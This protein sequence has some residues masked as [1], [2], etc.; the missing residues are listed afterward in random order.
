MI[1]RRGC[2]EI[3]RISGIIHCDFWSVIKI[4]TIWHPSYFFP[5]IFSDNNSIQRSYERVFSKVENV[6]KPLRLLIRPSANKTRAYVLIV[7]SAGRWKVKENGQIPPPIS[8]FQPFVSRFRSFPTFSNHPFCVGP[9]NGRFTCG[10]RSE[11]S[12]VRVTHP[13]HVRATRRRSFVQSQH[14][15]PGPMKQSSE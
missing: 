7:Y 9:C 13:P 3:Y 14:R 12:F 8:S 10:F 5:S 4:K 15:C 2:V 11:V 6:N 1:I